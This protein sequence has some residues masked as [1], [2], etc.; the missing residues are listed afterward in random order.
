L[1]V[2]DCFST[3]RSS[4]LQL[5]P[6]RNHI[7]KCEKSKKPP[8]KPSAT[9]KTSTATLRSTS[10][11]GFNFEDLIAAWQLV[12]ALAGEKAPGIESVATVIQAQVSSLGWRM[13]DL[14][15][16]SEQAGET[17]RLA[18]S[19]KGNQQVSNSGLP[20]DFVLR[21]WEQWRDAEGPFDAK[22]DGLALVTIGLNQ[23]F[24]ET[25]RSNECL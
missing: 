13:D 4:A 14:L 21:A 24:N 3:Q 22:T 7:G 2:F 18:I 9:R 20:D 16:K 23:D 25:W 6:R 19:A 11:A 17:R 15:L 8:R 1:K 12:K 5:W 10:G